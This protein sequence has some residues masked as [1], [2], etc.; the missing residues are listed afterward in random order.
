[1]ADRPRLLPFSSRKQ[2]RTSQDANRTDLSDAAT[3]VAGR[4]F[5]FAL[6]IQL[7]DALDPPFRHFDP[8]GTE[9]L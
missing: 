6:I 2:L 1:M 4:V 3:G 7:V 8:F 5:N 9:L